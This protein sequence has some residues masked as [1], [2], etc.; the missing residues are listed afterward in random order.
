MSAG[1]NNDRRHLAA[2]SAGL[3]LELELDCIIIIIIIIIIS[4]DIWLH[5]LIPRDTIIQLQ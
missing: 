3:L 5:C 1:E 4:L 2:C